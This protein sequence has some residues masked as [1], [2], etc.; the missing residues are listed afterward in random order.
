VRTVT[1][2]GVLVLRERPVPAFLVLR[3]YRVH[4]L[5]KGR[6]EA[7]EDELTCALRELG[8][9]TGIGPDDIALIP[10]RRFS[11]IYEVRSSEGPTRKTLVVFP[12]LLRHDVPIRLTEHHA[13]L[14]WPWERRT[15]LPGRIVPAII[16]QAEV[17]L[18]PPPWE[19][20][21]LAT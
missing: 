16:A 15:E 4:D 10:A 17:G 11:T 3:L 2:C 20:R 13:H 8:E 21:A 7:G 1:S 14:W 18:G 9:E 19:R 5:P 12:A 6:S